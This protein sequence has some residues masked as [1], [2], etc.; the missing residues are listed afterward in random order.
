MNKNSTKCY[1]KNYVY[2]KVYY[3]DILIPF[4]RNKEQ[5]LNSEIKR[6]VI[7]WSIQYHQ[8]CIDAYLDK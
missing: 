2:V 1:I 3:C 4:G 5:K 8:W 6:R 7:Y